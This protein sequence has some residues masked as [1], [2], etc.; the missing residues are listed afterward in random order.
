VLWDFV[1]TNEVGANLSA[2]AMFTH[3]QPTLVRKLRA[4]SSP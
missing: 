2:R 3:L 1:H 4:A